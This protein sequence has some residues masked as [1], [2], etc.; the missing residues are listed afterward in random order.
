M[1]FPGANAAPMM[2]PAPG[3]PLQPQ[4]A[5]FPMAAPAAPVAAPARPG[6]GAWLA[7]WPQALARLQQLGLP[8]LIIDSIGRQPMNEVELAQ[9]VQELE[10][11]HRGGA[12]GSKVLTPLVPTRRGQSPTQQSPA[13]SSQAAA[14]ANLE[15]VVAKHAKLGVPKDLLQ[16]LAEAATTPQGLDATLK[17]L[18]GRMDK[19]RTAGWVDKF[20]KAG[21]EDAIIWQLAL[22]GDPEQ[23]TVVGPMPKDDKLAMTLVML[24]RSKAG[25]A[26]QFLEAGVSLIPGVQAG[27]YLLGKNVISGSDIRRH[28]G[29]NQILAGVSALALGVVALGKFRSAKT[30]MSGLQAARNGYS[31]LVG[32]TGRELAHGSQAAQLRDLAGPGKI[33]FRKAFLSKELRTGFQGMAHVEAAA[34]ARS[35]ATGHALDPIG[36]TISDDV[37]RRIADGTLT[38]GTKKLSSTQVLSGAHSGGFNTTHGVAELSDDALLFNKKLKIST[39]ASQLTGIIRAGGDRMATNPGYLADRLPALSTRIAGMS[40]AE[41]AGVGET[42]AGMSLAST[43]KVARDGAPGRDLNKLLI[44]DPSSPALAWYRD[45][46]AAQRG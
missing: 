38:T 25:A 4:A 33:T 23:G 27:E 43:G 3:A 41:R 44:K 40:Q 42:I 10:T 5:P 14:V 22:G 2:A 31:G 35:G 13:Q 9:A 37:L 29:L 36:R 24:Q 6:T 19:L 11:G 7:S 32:A 30:L 17:Q 34:S 46:L 28:D 39:G 1:M 18:E 45:A 12:Q 16:T 20:H 26:R 21:A 15:Q 8:S